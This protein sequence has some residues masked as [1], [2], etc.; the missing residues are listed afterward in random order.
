[1]SK[2]YISRQHNKGSYFPLPSHMELKCDLQKSIDQNLKR[3]E[4]PGIE[5]V[6]HA[7]SHVH[8]KHF[9]DSLFHKLCVYFP[10]SQAL[11]G[12]SIHGKAAS[13][14][15]LENCRFSYSNFFYLCYLGLKPNVIKWISDVNFTWNEL[16]RQPTML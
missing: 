1:M 16:G 12:F 15:S 9:M 2:H 10:N 5:G 14:A 3:P 4:T 6:Q 13:S 7:T 8:N 11:R